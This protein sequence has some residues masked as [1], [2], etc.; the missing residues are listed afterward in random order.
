MNL[1]KSKHWRTNFIA[2]V[3]M[4][5]FVAAGLAVVFGFATFADATALLS[6]VAMPLMYFGFKFTADGKSVDD[7]QYTT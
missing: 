2:I 3:A 1:K 4:L 6:T 5:L 7:N